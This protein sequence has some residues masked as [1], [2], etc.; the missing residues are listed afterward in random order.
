MFTEEI[1]L[2]CMYMTDIPWWSMVLTFVSSLSTLGSCIIAFEIWRVTKKYADDTQRYV[3]I[4]EQM[5]GDLRTPSLQLLKSDSGPMLV[6]MSSG[7]IFVLSVRFAGHGL[8]A[9]R[10]NEG[11]YEKSF[12]LEP[13]QTELIMR[14]ETFGTP[15]LES[16][17]PV[18]VEFL[19]GPTGSRVYKQD[20]VTPAQFHS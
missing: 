5:R 1:D 18:Q 20:L 8:V 16:E 11:A 14:M 2:C 7:F 19:F 9:G 13:G 10:H 6:N 12:I 3:E 15:K 17:L 4:N